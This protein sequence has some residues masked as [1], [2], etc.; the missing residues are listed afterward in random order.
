[1]FWLLLTARRL[2]NSN[3]IICSK[4]WEW[5][6]WWNGAWSSCNTWFA[7]WWQG[8]NGANG[9]CVIMIYWNELKQWTIDVSWWNGWVW[10]W[11]YASTYQC[12]WRHREASGTNGT[13]WSY[14][15]CKF[16]Y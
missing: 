4:G 1:M 7:C 12:E 5:W 9:W 13:A 15:V 14:K 3:W 11:T 10:W 16:T 2:D 6:A 8:W